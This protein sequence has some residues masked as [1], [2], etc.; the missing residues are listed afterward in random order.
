MS[1]IQ[2]FQ[3]D[4]TTVRTLQQ[5]G[6][7][8]LFVA[9]DVALALGYANPADAIITH[10]R[11]RSYLGPVPLALPDQQ[12][13]HLIGLHSETVL[14]PES[15]VYRLVMRS[16]LESAERFQDWVVEEVLP[17]L[18]KTGR[19]EVNKPI[20]KIDAL[21]EMVL[22]MQAQERRIEQLELEQAKTAQAVVEMLGG[23]D[24]STAKGYARTHKLS[25][26]RSFLQAV[27]VRATQL[28]KL[29][30]LNVSK[31]NDEVWG[32]VNSYPRD[33][34]ATAFDEMQ[35]AARVLRN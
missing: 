30:G 12:N 7:E 24:Y 15:D 8:P 5:D 18:R 2:I 21:V 1:A 4:T 16:Q 6:A 32:Q 26:D 23:E 33:I 13:Q 31:V 14:I 17:T 27:G 19:Y 28:C 25:A 34:L 11:R 9:K 3:F 10:C 20:K 22:G 35:A 29:H